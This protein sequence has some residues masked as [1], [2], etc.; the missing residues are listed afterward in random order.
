[1]WS[2]LYKMIIN[3]LALFGNKKK[4]NFKSNEILII[5]NNQQL[6]DEE[7]GKLSG[8]KRSESK[9]SLNNDSKITHNNKIHK[10]SNSTPDIKINKNPKNKPSQVSNIVTVWIPLFGAWGFVEHRK[11]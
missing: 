2:Y 5:P 1:M 10:K 11:K 9:S 4:V 8:M 6:L 3:F 7:I